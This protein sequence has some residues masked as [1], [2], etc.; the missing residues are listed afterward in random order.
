MYYALIM[1]GGSGTRLWPFS[2]RKHPKQML[3][4]DGERTLF[5]HAVERLTPLFQPQQILVVTRTEHVDALAA[6]APQLPL[7]NFIVEPEGRGTAPAIGLGA[8]TLRQRNPDAIMAVLT[9]DHFIAEAERFRQILAA[10]ARVAEEGHLV[11]LGIRPTYPSTGYGYIKQGKLVR[12]ENGFPVFQVE[13]FVEKPNPELARAL[14]ENREY[15]W[16]GGMFIWRV[17]RILAEIQHQMPEFY[18]QLM[19][20]EAALGTPNSGPVLSRV[21]S[22]V[23]RQTIDYGVMEGAQDVVVIPA[24][25]GWS[26]IGSWTSLV[27][28]L[29]TDEDKN[30]VVG[31][32]LGMD[33][34]DTLVMNQ[35]TKRLVV[36][37]GVEQMVVVSMDDV[38]LVCSKKQAQ[39]VRTIVQ[40]LEQKGWDDWL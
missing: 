12:T 1:A 33:T 16:N 8:I 22:Q 18:A 37:I 27:N 15:S 3:S 29:G 2:R 6:Q 30:T 36:T 34:C 11:T 10:A 31:P 7:E 20:V 32:H 26:D 4:V 13:Q 5:A 19:E 24:D 39:D 28:V 17:E 9:A 40:R 35:G 38:V 23:A 21:W 25:I 14:V